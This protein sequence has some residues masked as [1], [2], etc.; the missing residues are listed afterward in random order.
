MSGV[1]PYSSVVPARATAPSAGADKLWKQAQDFET[2]FFEN[3]LEHLTSGL[4]DDGPLG[5]GGIGGDV[6]RGMLSQQY[7]KS[8]TAAGGVGIAQNVYRELVR[9]QEGR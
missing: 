7:A 2:V 8:V 4:G 3:M 1:A 5:E 9:L 6:Y